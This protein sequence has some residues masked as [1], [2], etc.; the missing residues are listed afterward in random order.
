MELVKA[1]QQMEAYS[2]EL[3]VD[4]STAPTFLVHAKDDDV[5]PVANSTVFYDQLRKNNVPAEI[6]LYEKGGHGFGM[7]NPTSDVKWVDLVIGWLNEAVGGK[8]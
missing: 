7:N 3:L 4:K 2:N 6:Y 1:I 8:Q 5:V